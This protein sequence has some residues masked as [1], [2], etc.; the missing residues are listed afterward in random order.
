M[1]GVAILPPCIFERLYVAYSAFKRHSFLTN[2]PTQS[3]ILEKTPK[4]G[5]RERVH[6]SGRDVKRSGTRARDLVDAA[7]AIARLAPR[8]WITAAKNGSFLARARVRVLY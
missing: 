4:T 3:K 8:L 6:L 1:R 7:E 2:E 5:E